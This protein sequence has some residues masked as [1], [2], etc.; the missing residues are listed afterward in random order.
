MRVQN[1]KWKTE[2]FKNLTKYKRTASRERG[3]IVIAK[4]DYGGL[5]VIVDVKNYTRGVESQLKTGIIIID[6]IIWSTLVKQIT[7]D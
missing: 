5:V 1:G 7:A 4:T 3:D 2:P 6:N